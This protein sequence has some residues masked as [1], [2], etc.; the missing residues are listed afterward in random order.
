M[1]C[2]IGSGSPV[3]DDATG[4]PPEPD[5]DQ[6]SSEREKVFVPFKASYSSAKRYRICCPASC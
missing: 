3:N 6:G 5:E 1:G 4:P 2:E